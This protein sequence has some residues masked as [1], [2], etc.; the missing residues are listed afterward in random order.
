ML[1]RRKKR[2]GKQVRLNAKFN[3]IEAKKKE[4]ITVISM[5]KNCL[6]PNKHLVSKFGAF[7]SSCFIFSSSSF[8]VSRIGAG[9][10]K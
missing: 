4:K 6:S 2:R 9:G 3:G 7:F 8:S 1:D 10:G 5:G